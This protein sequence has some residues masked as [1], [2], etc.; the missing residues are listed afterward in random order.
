MEELWKPVDG[1]NGRYKVSTYGRVISYAQDKQNGKF[2][3]CS[4]THKGYLTVALYDG[5]GGKKFYPV[6]RLVALAFIENPNN[7]EQVNH[8][9]EDK[10]NNHV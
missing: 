6:H 7:Y 4:K 5:N 1:Y 8:K 9:D 3:T 10:A 2:M